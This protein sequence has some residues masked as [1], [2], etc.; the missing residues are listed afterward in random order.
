MNAP[1]YYVVYQL[2]NG[3]LGHIKFNMS[4]AGMSS[5]ELFATISKVVKAQI[6]DSENPSEEFVITNIINLHQTFGIQ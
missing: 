3:I 5:N 4:T 1:T 6:Q 2:S